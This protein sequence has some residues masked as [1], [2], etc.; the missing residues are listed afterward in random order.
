MNKVVHHL[1]LF[2]TITILVLLITPQQAFSHHNDTHALTLFRLQADIHGHL[3][4]NWTGSDACSS[5]AP[6][7]GVSCSPNNRVTTL[8]LPSLNLRGPLTPLSFLTHLRFLDLHDNRL[9]GTIAPLISNCT[10]LMLL[11]LSGNDLSGEIPP[12]ISS[13]T[14]LL[15]LDLSGNNIGGKV[16]RELL[17]LTKL[18][19]LRLQDNVLN[20]FIPDLSSSMENLSELNMT[21]NEL[22]GKLPD[23][24]L[25]KFGAESFYGN[26]GLCGASP[27]PVCSFANEN[28]PPNY[29]GEDGHDDDLGQTVPSNPSSMPQTSQ[30]AR[31]GTQHHHHKRLSPGA[32][33][34]IVLAN[35]VALVVVTSFLVA[36]CC[37]RE[38]GSNS[39]SYVGSESGKRKSN[40]SSTSG[41]Y[42]SEKNKSR[43]RSKNKKVYAN[44]IVN[45]GGDSDGTSGSDGSKLVFFDR[46]NQ[47]ELEDLLRASAE[48]LGKGSLGTVYRAVL[49]D[50][51]TVAVKR[52][53]DANP[54]ARNE[55]EQYMEVIG[56]LK[57]PNIV[58]L[59]AYYYAKEEK[60]L[61]Y[62]YL[63]NGSLHALLHGNRGPG[64]IPLDWTT[65]I[66]LVLGAA[67]GLAKI[68]AEYSSA[69]VPHGNVKSS[70]V[71][72]DKNGV[73]C[74]SDFGLSLL[75]NPVH[76]IARLG[77]YRAPEQA[78]QKRLS[79]QADV[80]SFGVL[81]LEVL[82]GRAPSSTYPSPAR[83]RSGPDEEE[84]LAVDLPKW[85]R[86][87]VK[88]EWTG[89]VFDQE[90]LRYK[91]IEEE[92]VSM[93]HVGLACV[94]PQ[95]EKRPTMAEV[96][97]MIEEIRVEQSPLRED[98]DESR[99]SLSPSLPTTEDGVV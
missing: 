67:R 47:F 53:K 54:C 89:E 86:S 13:V 51:C 7:R 44:G 57:H 12:E 52:L 99:N 14:G 78:E 2:F 48:M 76:A 25:K 75:L 65:R 24:M 39:G 3:L 50:G 59:R 20:G 31:P 64:R 33:V 81:L 15:R 68:H 91:N 40:G 9:N 30:V 79:Q 41:G 73:A 34:A 66:S 56:R 72:L 88:E 49:D 21:N 43:N 8:S 69:K 46:R 98:Y 95:P 37:G 16:P 6:W 87:V 90:L 17:N 97:K 92:L 19:T 18:L 80:Y 23:P 83:P 42:G 58:R 55:F 29:G 35:C 85:V 71:L 36:Q 1:I 32:I 96:A 22:Y 62:D 94:A 45:G 28:S 74:I 70:N 60:L 4:P 10:N 61:V 27:L 63:P 38:R 93:L 11:Y 84:E 77:G 82:T 26:E 5:A